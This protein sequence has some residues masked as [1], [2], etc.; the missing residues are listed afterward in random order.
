MAG[1]TRPPASCWR[2]PRS[3]TT[4]R[5]SSTRRSSVSSRWRGWAATAASCSAAG[6]RPRRPLEEWLGDMR[7]YLDI[8]FGRTGEIE[9]V[10]VPQIWD[11]EC[12]WKFATD[13]FTDNFHVFCDA[14]EPG[15]ARHAA[16]RSGLRLA[17]PHGH[18][19]QRP[20][21][22]LRAGA[23]RWRRSRA[24]VCRKSLWPR[25]RNISSPAQARIAQAHG[26][27]AG[28]MWPNFHWLQL[29]T[30]GD[31]KSEPVGILNLRLES[32]AEPDAH[33]HVL[34]VRDRQGGARG[35]PQDLLRDL[36]AH[37]SAPPASSTR[38]TW[39]T[40]RSAPR[41]ARPGGQALHAAP[42]DGPRPTH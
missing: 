20:H 12:S 34:L 9:F 40:G 3:I 6:T 35:L 13:N 29:V 22:A 2:R 24:W 28:T 37:A 15:R 17:W 16:E 18:A 23:A 1:P 31:T 19:R 25:S 21:P 38:T 11:V 36:R 32:P 8:I 41:G 42:Q 33:A 39:R 10:G 30:A 4:A 14:P 27:S 7:W 26:Y 5:A